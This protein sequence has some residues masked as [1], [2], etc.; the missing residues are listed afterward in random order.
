MALSGVPRRGADLTAGLQRLERAAAIGRD[1]ARAHGT[2]ARMRRSRSW[3]SAAC[4]VGYRA[5]LEQAAR[6]VPAVT[7]SPV[8]YARRRRAV[9]HVPAAGT[10]RLAGGRG[11]TQRPAITVLRE[12]GSACIVYAGARS[13]R[14]PLGGGA[15]AGRR[16]ALAERGVA[17]GAQRIRAVPGLVDGLHGH[18]CFA[19][20]QRLAPSTQRRDSRAVR[21]ALGARPAAATR[22]DVEHRGRPL[23]LDATSCFHGTDRRSWSQRAS[24]Y[25]RRHALA[26]L[27]VVGFRR[28]SDQIV[29]HA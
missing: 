2:C 26:L 29:T 6:H 9:E 8:R 22:Q 16:R 1:R 5:L 3:S 15:G 4:R 23:T 12:L 19:A 10:Q 17:R 18:P 13:R 11:A 25:G 27:G 14:R 21:T 28:R 7:R 24:G 20:D